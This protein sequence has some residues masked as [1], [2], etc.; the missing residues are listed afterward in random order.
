MS[1]QGK[2]EETA[3]LLSSK[4]NREDLRRS[5]EQLD[6]GEGK[7]RD[8]LPLDEAIEDIVTHD[9]PLLDRLADEDQ[10]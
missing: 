7:E 6:A 9:K 5:I 3:Y 2:H 4:A 10:D 1:D 8:L